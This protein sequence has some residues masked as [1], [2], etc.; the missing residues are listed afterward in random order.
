MFG[1][2]GQANVVFFPLA[3]MTMEI[4]SCHVEDLLRLGLDE[5][6]AERTRGAS[7]CWC[8]DTWV[9]SRG[10]RWCYMFF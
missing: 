4:H 7:G 6:L 3:T 5:V 8:H 2:L 9:T 1:S 10:P